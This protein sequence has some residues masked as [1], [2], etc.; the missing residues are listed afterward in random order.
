MCVELSGQPSDMC[1][2]LSGQPSDMCVELS[3]QP[4]DMCVEMNGHLLHLD[5]TN[6]SNSDSR[7]E[8]DLVI[9]SDYYWELTTGKT[10][11]SCPVAIQTILGWVL[12]G[13]VEFPDQPLSPVSLHTTHT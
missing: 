3:G 9:S 6:S 5:L 13:P 11:Q 10:R 2:E 1:V 7:I 8:V 12:T 4:S